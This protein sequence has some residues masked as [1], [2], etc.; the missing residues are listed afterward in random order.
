MGISGKYQVCNQPKELICQFFGFILRTR[1]WGCFL[2]SPSAFQTSKQLE[3]TH[4]RFKQGL[5][6]A[7][8]LEGPLNTHID[9]RFHLARLHFTQSADNSPSFL[10]MLLLQWFSSMLQYHLTKNQHLLML[11]RIFQVLLLLLQARWAQWSPFTLFIRTW[12]FSRLQSTSGCV[13]ELPQR[14]VFVLKSVATPHQLR[15]RILRSSYVSLVN[16]LII[17]CW[18]ILTKL[19]FTPNSLPASQFGVISPKY[20]FLWIYMHLQWHLTRMSTRR[21]II[22]ILLAVASL[23]LLSWK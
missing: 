10:L 11:E 19:V 22:A 13:I 17:S 7:I 18:F 9:L 4:S 21:R 5:L 20:S 15:R 2:P 1:N 3:I 6:Q 23:Y 16:S 8:L 14:F 12:V